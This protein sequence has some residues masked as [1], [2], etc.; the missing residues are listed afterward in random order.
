MYT[1]SR[2]SFQERRFSSISMD[3]LLEAAFQ[4]YNWPK[5]EAGA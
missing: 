2:A 5:P 1:R 4:G 3:S